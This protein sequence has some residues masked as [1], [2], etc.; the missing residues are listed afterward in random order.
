MRARFW[1]RK[2]CLVDFKL[3][4]SEIVYQEVKTFLTLR[5]TRNRGERSIHLQSM[6]TIIII[7]ATHPTPNTDAELYVE[8]MTV[9]FVWSVEFGAIRL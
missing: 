8:E 7:M 9:F 6:T 2:S 1:R 3:K 4:G 5:H